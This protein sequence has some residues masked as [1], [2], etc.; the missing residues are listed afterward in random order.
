MKEPACPLRERLYRPSRSSIFRVAQLAR[1][2][3]GLNVF[4]TPLPFLTSFRSSFFG[5]SARAFGGVR[6]RR[7]LTRGQSALGVRAS[8]VLAAL[9]ADPPLCRRPIVI[10]A[11]SRTEWDVARRPAEKLPPA[12][13]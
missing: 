11:A 7:V 10:L 4:D 3:I 9:H 12:S 5:A 2:G 1:R 13:A 6:R 8:G